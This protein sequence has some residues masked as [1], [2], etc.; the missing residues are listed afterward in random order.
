MLIFQLRLENI[1]WRTLT[2]NCFLWSP[3]SGCGSWLVFGLRS[4][5]WEQF[6]CWRRG[7]T[8]LHE[9]WHQSRST[10]GFK[11]ISCSQSLNLKI[12]RVVQMNIKNYSV[13]NWGLQYWFIVVNEA[14][15]RSSVGL[16][17]R[18]VAHFLTE[19]EEIW[20][21]RIDAAQV[22]CDICRQVRQKKR[23]NFHNVLYSNDYAA[24]KKSIDIGSVLSYLY[25]HKWSQ[26]CQ[27]QWSLQ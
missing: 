6:L 17:Y 1:I 23:K 9:K 5:R 7:G 27:R 8:I 18:N 2:V 20:T 3:I 26:R 15:W 4:I 16:A 11:N 21:N 25:G 22:Y 14:T 13:S 19:F 24:S 10:L 12:W